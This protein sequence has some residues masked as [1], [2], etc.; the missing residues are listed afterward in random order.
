[1]AAAPLRSLADD[2]RGRGDDQLSA[3]ILARPDLVHPV[4]TDLAALAQRAGSPASISAA[5]RG[6]DQLMLQVVL[7]AALGPDP[8]A[9]SDL[10][11]AVAP[12][13][14]SHVPAREA[15]EQVRQAVDRLRLEALLWGSDRALHLVGSARDLVVPADRGPRIAALDPVVARYWRDPDALRALLADAP[16]G[17]RAALDRLLAGSVVGTVVDARR[18]PDP[19]RSPVD[20]LLAHHLLVALGTDRAVVPGEVVAILRG[21][22]TPEAAARPDQAVASLAPP[23]P[24]APAPDPHRTQSG[25]VGAVLDMVHA[26]A[27]LGISWIDEPPARLRTGGVAQRDLAR[28]ARTLGMAEPVAALVIEVAAAAG[29]VAAD[30][31]EDATV[32]PTPA[33]DVWLTQAPAAQHADLLLAWRDMPRTVAR[34]EQR[35]MDPELAAPALPGLRREVLAALA[36]ADGAWTPD[37]LVAAMAWRAPRRHEPSRG[38]G[39]VGI[40]AELHTLGVAVG[41]VLTG[42]GRALAADDRAGLERA[43]AAVLPAQVDTLVMQAD[44]TAIVPG[45]PTAELAALMRLVARPESTGAASVYRFTARASGRPW[46]RAARPPSCSVRSADAARSPSRWPTWS[47]TSPAATP[48]CASALPPRTC[49]ATTPCCWGRSWPTPRRWAWACSDSPTRSWQVT[50]HPST[51][52]T[53]FVAWATGR[54]PSRDADPRHRHRAARGPAP[55]RPSRPRLR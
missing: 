42:A 29:L 51:C 7:A 28:T 1:M 34:P 54:N 40:L 30:N 52:W 20:W 25:A 35:P 37:E 19:E 16:D 17:A 39:A 10:V 47:R 2:L 36:S 55:S 18:V 48:R 33:F 5:L 53:G 9:P 45:L 41:G 11:R 27:E 46:T 43:L 31:A 50:N 12:H 3:L 4:P 22:V 32:L 26:V 49:A 44:L 24:A 38:A 15:R 21:A 13:V 23:R 6:Y 8:V 14:P